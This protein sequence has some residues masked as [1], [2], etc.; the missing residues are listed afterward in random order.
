MLKCEA[1]PKGGTLATEGLQSELYIGIITASLHMCTC[2]VREARATGTWT[3]L[4][5]LQEELF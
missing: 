5:L 3:K 4:L 2:N 1:V